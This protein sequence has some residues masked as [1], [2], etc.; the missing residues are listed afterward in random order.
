MLSAAAILEFIYFSQNLN[1]SLHLTL[2]WEARL[3][4]ALG[5]DQDL[6]LSTSLY[7]K[8]PGI[9]KHSLIL[10]FLPCNLSST[11]LWEL[12][13]KSGMA[14]LSLR[15]ISFTIFHVLFSRGFFQKIDL[16][17]IFPR[18]PCMYPS[19]PPPA[20]ASSGYPFY[21][22]NQN[23]LKLPPILPQPLRKE[24]IGLPWFMITLIF[25]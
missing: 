13:L 7:I 12:F 11:H 1:I 2:G 4:P 15:L 20:T 5:S 6:I 8:L 10:S 17:F 9:S 14:S 22:A 16:P 24:H 25:I 19:S 23:T 3:K 21:S 18:T